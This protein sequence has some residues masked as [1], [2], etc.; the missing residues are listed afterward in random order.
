M[1]NNKLFQKNRLII[2]SEAK[3]NCEKC[4]KPAMD[5]HHKDTNRSHH[6]LKNLMALC[7]SCHRKIHIKL[8]PKRYDKMVQTRMGRYGI[9]NPKAKAFFEKETFEF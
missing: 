8:D 4:G 6:S 7:R 5:V 2:L 9:Y 1:K 3:F